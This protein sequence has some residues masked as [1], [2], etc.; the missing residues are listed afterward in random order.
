MVSEENV[1]SSNL[2]STTE[3]MQLI[4]GA[5]E[6]NDESEKI[7]KKN[8]PS[9]P[10]LKSRERFNDSSNSVSTI[11]QEEDLPQTNSSSVPTTSSV[12]QY[13]VL[14]CKRSG[15]RVSTNSFINSKVL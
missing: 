1:E 15:K 12:S 7:I 11:S 3:I 13:N 9:L 10:R 14:W 5:A 2:R 6:N 8:T 4:L